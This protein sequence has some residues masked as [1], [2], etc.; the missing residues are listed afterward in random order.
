MSEPWRERIRRWL[1]LKPPLSGSFD[2][3]AFERLCEEDPVAARDALFLDQRELTDELERTYATYQEKL[4]GLEARIRCIPASEVKQEA[5]G[6]REAQDSIRKTLRRIEA[7]ARSARDL[8]AELLE[9]EARQ[10]EDGPLH[11]DHPDVRVEIVRS[12]LVTRGS[13]PDMRAIP[14]EETPFGRVG[15]VMP[16]RMETEGETV[17]MPINLEDE[18]I[19]LPD[20]DPDQLVRTIRQMT[21]EAERGLS[22]PD[23]EPEAIEDLRRLRE[24]HA[25]LKRL[26]RERGATRDRI[27]LAVRME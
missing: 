6:L 22:V 27:A 18:D 26:D 19:E 10:G 2:P 3:A 13:A 8:E 4:K 24:L 11:A 17:E 23:P 20:P 15:C 1:R 16:A 7:S 21:R 14:M 5:E 12:E 25:L 9:W